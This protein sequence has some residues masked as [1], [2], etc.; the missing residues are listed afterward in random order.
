MTTW[1]DAE[2]S[3]WELQDGKQNFDDWVQVKFKEEF[4]VASV[5]WNA[6]DKSDMESLFSAWVN[7]TD[8]VDLTRNARG[9]AA[10]AAARVAAGGKA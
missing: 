3:V 9:E 6:G 1:T 4:D 8:A 7:T 10:A 2:G 5:K